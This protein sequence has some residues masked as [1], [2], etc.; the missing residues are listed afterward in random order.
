MVKVKLH[1]KVKVRVYSLI[2]CPCDTSVYK[3]KVQDYVIVKVKVQDYVKVK[4]KAQD[5][6]NIKVMVK[7]KLHVKVKVRVYSLIHCPCDPFVFKVK[8]QDYVNVEV[9]VKVNLLSQ[10]PIFLQNQCK[11]HS[12]GQSP[13]LCQYQGHCLR[14]SCR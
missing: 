3:V 9:M 14:S 8:F 13:R 6:V 11:G 1:M 4:V 2:H 10:H 12:H 7:V 5:Y